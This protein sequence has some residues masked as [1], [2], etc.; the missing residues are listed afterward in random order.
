MLSIIIKTTSIYL[1]SF[2][3][4]FDSKAGISNWISYLKYAISK[5]KQSPH[6]KED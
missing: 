5:E 3:I 4:V 6:S 1:T 2:Y